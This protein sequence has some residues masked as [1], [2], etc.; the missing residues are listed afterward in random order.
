MD[1]VSLG[2]IPECGGRELA[3]GYPDLLG[4]YDALK[5]R[6]YERYIRFNTGLVKQ[7][8]HYTGVI[9]ECYVKNVRQIVAS[10]GRY[11][12]L[13][14]KFGFDCPAIGFSVNVN[15]LMSVLP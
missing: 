6:G 2:Y 9:F 13:I 15:P 14:G 1:Y 3:E 12:H 5:D 10:G 4:I 11:D 8:Y 7:L